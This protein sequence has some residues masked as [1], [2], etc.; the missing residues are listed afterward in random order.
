[1]LL[2]EGL[3]AYEAHGEVSMHVISLKMIKNFIAMH[4]EAKAPLLAIYNILAASD[5]ETNDEL[6]STFPQVDYVKPFHVFNVGRAYRL[7][8]AIHFNRRKVY[9]RHIMT[10]REYDRGKW[11]PK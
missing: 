6:R 9:V 10:H 8:V 1:M 7:M 2:P 11:K 4:P 3:P 5:F